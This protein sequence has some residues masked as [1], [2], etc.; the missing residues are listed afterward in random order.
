MYTNNNKCEQNEHEAEKLLGK[1]P[2]DLILC[3]L[4]CPQDAAKAFLGAL[5]LTDFRARPLHFSF[6]SPIRPTRLQRILYGATLDEHLKID[7]IAQKLLKDIPK[8]PDVLFVDAPELLR[9][10]RIIKFPTAFLTKSTNPKAQPGKLSTLE[11]DTG[12][13][14]ADQEIVGQILATLE[15]VV[16][17]V[18]PFT[19]MREAL[20]EAIKSPK[21]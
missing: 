12:S 11:Y 20:K 14:I 7:V 13:N 9:V 18:E 5:I 21:E 4:T 16:D 6:V 8:S 3:Y 17:L 2:P 1:D 15:T 10:R 19:R